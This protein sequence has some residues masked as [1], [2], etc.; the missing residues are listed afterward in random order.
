MVVGHDAV[1]VDG[2]DV[3]VLTRVDTG[4][5]AGQG[6]RRRVRGESYVS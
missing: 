1:R 5:L 6:G 2:E 3:L 4:G